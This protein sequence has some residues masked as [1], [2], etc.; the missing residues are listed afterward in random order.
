MKKRSKSMFQGTWGSVKS[1]KTSNTK[2]SHGGNDIYCTN[3]NCN[4]DICY[5]DE[6]C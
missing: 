3:N 4:G 5:K 2:S 6:H 1:N